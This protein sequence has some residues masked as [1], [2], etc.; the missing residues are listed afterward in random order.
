VANSLGF[1]QVAIFRICE[2]AGH[3][4][5][6]PHAFNSAS[7]HSSCSARGVYDTLDLVQETKKVVEEAGVQAILIPGDLSE[8]AICK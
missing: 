3:P 1:R 7:A 2:N 8:E 5:P 6:R 4:W